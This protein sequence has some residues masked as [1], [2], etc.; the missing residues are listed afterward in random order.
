MFKHGCE[1]KYANVIIELKVETLKVLLLHLQLQGKQLTL[2]S[3]WQMHAD[4]D[5]KTGSNWRAS[6][7]WWL[8]W[9]CPGSS[10]GFHG[11]VGEF[12]TA[13]WIT[14]LKTIGQCFRCPS[15]PTEIQRRKSNALRLDK[16]FALARVCTKEH[17]SAVSR[18]ERWCTRTLGWRRDRPGVGWWPGA[19]SF[20]GGQQADREPERK[21]R[22][23]NTARPGRRVTWLRVKEQSNR[24]EKNRA[25]AGLVS[26]TWTNCQ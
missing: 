15:A 18:V 13:K 22:E 3:A 26:D 7:G 23:E 17:R 14:D 11:L 9:N 4:S 6:W 21:G 1:K 19:A 12:M 25:Y 5:D 8:F 2:L 24:G 20:Q 10:S 16:T